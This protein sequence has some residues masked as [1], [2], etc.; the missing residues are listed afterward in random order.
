MEKKI[1]QKEE[2]DNFIHPSQEDINS[3]NEWNPPI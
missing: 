2:I 3:T 1:H